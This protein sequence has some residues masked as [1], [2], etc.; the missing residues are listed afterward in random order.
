MQHVVKGDVVLVPPQTPHWYPEIEGT[1]TYLEI[2]FDVSAPVNAPAVFMSKTSLMKL[3][4]ERVAAPNAPLMV[5]S[6][7]TTAD[8]YQANIVHRT[9]PQGVA[10]HELG[11]EVHQII[12]GSGTFVTG[13]TVARPAA[14][15][16]GISTITG[17]ESRHVQAGDVVFV[18][19]NVPHWYKDL[20][21]PISY[22]EVRFELPK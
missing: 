18:P 9:K 10:Q 11:T 17:G 13:G 6:P 7:V 1:I 2:R 3:L 14:G 5:T 19:A 12:E 22:L 20:D 8:K 4:A 16:Q 15:T 21:G